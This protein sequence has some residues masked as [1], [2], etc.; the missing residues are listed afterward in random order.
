MTGMDPV[1]MT[2]GAI[3]LLIVAFIAFRLVRQR[4]KGVPVRV[5]LVENRTNLGGEGINWSPVFRIEDGEYA[6]MTVT[7][8]SRM[9]KPH[10]GGSGIAATYDPATD[11]IYTWQSTRSDLL[12]ALAFALL[13]AIFVIGAVMIGR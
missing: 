11:T 12:T 10:K 9:S 2:A 8:I 3:C 5:F 7:S 6:G 4:M 13:G 1:A